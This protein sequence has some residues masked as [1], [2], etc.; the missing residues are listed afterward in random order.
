M[1]L[2]LITLMFIC[3]PSYGA[4]ML[5]DDGLLVCKI[6]FSTSVA[7]SC[8]IRYGKSS[9]D[10]MELAKFKHWEWTLSAGQQTD[11]DA[12]VVTEKAAIKSDQGIP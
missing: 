10:D 1:R 12:L 5:K 7:S 3:L 6:D 11:L 4:K 9:D 2:L 8:Y